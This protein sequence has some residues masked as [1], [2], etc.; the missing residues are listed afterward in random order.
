[1][2]QFFEDYSKIIGLLMLAF[3]IIFLFSTPSM[4]LAKS[5]TTIGTELSHATG[6]ELCVRT[7]MDFGNNEHMQAFPKQIGDWTASDYNT[8]EITERLQ[9][10][11]IL[12]RAYS[13][14]KFYQPIFFL[15]MQSENRSSFHPPIVCYPA[16]GYTIEEEGK[17]LIPVQDVSWTEDPWLSE[18]N[19]TRTVAL[20]VKKLVVVK[21]AEENGK[22]TE[23]RVVLYYYVKDRPFTSDTVTMIRVS[24]LA[25]IE[26]SYDGPLTISKDFM[27]ATVP[28]MFEVQRAE[29]TLFTSLASGS[30]AD[31]VALVMLFL[32]PLA[33]LFYPELRAVSYGRSR[34]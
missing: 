31:K 17:E 18:K 22:I 4:I 11:V 30:I 34:K 24:A 1:M 29:P 6:D 27:G 25:P 20:S 7:K 10:D 33:V 26:G 8:A 23:R 15:V 19:V 28:C 21:E 9:A 12:M 2:Q 3:V 13:H 32:A 16:L 14:P 5:V